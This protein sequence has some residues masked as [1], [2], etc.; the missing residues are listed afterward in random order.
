[1]NLN[2]AD[3]DAANKTVKLYFNCKEIRRFEGITYNDAMRKGRLNGADAL[4]I[5]T[6]GSAYPQCKKLVDGRFE[7]IHRDKFFASYFYGVEK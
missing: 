6:E 2:Q 1:M 4:I 7:T 5:I 3:M